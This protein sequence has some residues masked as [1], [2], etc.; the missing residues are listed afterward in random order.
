[1]FFRRPSTASTAQHSTAQP[2]QHNGTNNVGRADHSATM[3]AK[4]DRAAETYHVA[5][6]LLQLAVLSKQTNT[7]K[8]AWPK[9][10]Y[11]HKQQL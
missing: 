4:R 6:H 10:I 8:A 7:W 3:Q 2:V 11:N 9:D 1:M 5:E